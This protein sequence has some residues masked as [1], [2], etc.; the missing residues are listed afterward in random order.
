MLDGASR[1]TD[2]FAEAERLGMPALALTDHG[3]MY[4]AYDFYKAG[5]ARGVKPIIGVE[6]Y[7]APQGRKTKSPIEFG[8][9][10]RAL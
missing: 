4:G 8:G 9:D 6:G 3:Y 5:L 10:M 1:L 2:L 7:Y